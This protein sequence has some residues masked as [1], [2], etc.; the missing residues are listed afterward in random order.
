MHKKVLLPSV[1]KIAIILGM[2]IM[3]SGQVVL[4]AQQSISPP[5]NLPNTQIQE[6]EFVVTT[7]L[8]IGMGTPSPNITLPDIEIITYPKPVLT[9]TLDHTVFLPTIMHNYVDYY[10]DFSNPSSGWPIVNTPA[11]IYRY[12]NNEYQILNL[13]DNYVAATTVGNRLVD[14]EMSVEMR[15]NGSAK[16]AYGLVFGL[17][18]TWSEYFMFLIW[19][20]S[21][22]WSIYQYQSGQGFTWQGNGTDYCIRQGNQSNHLRFEHYRVFGWFGTLTE[23]LI[24]INGCQRGV[25]SVA[26]TYTEARRVGMIAVPTDAGHDV[27]FDNYHFK[28]HPTIIAGFN[29]G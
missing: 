24:Y 14:F 18:D 12:I 23:R 15:R 19:P 2:L 28:N 17:D 22:E 8:P 6:N 11:N 4:L 26:F 3:L 7:A 10:D 21:Q 1:K 29:N 16:G 5:E 13:T 25:S 9:D 20:D 27:R